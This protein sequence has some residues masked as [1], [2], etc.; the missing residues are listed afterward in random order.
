M[1]TYR[2]SDE[3]TVGEAR[4]L[5]CQALRTSSGATAVRPRSNAAGHHMEYMLV[6]TSLTCHID[7]TD[8]LI[9]D[10]N[11]AL[12]ARNRPSA[13]PPDSTRLVRPRFRLFTC[14]CSK[15]ENRLAVGTLE[16]GSAHLRWRGGRF[17]QRHHCESDWRRS[18]APTHTT[19]HAT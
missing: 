19:R 2:V 13:P 12:A 6:D 10:L 5:W 17:S 11:A 9:D 16:P 3:T 8:A 7:D 14:P 15:F 18:V 1:Q 4:F